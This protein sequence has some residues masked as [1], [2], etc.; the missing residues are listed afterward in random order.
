MLG[1]PLVNSLR[2]RGLRW[3]IG[4]IADSHSGAAN[5]AVRIAWT[6]GAAEGSATEGDGAPE[7]NTASYTGL[8]PSNKD[9]GRKKIE[10]AFRA[11]RTV[12]AGHYWRAFFEPAR[13]VHNVAGLGK[14]PN[15]FYYWA[16]EDLDKV[17]VFSRTPGHAQ[18]IEPRATLPQSGDGYFLPPNT[19]LI[20]DS[21]GSVTRWPNLEFTKTVPTTLGTLRFRYKP[22]CRTDAVNVVVAHE[23]THRVCYQEAVVN[24][25]AGDQDHDQVP[26]QWEAAFG[27]S[28][29]PQGRQDSFGLNLPGSIQDFEFYAYINGCFAGGGFRA[30]IERQEP[31][32]TWVDVT[33]TLTYHGVVP[34][35][36]VRGDDWSEDGYRW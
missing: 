17:C 19:L 16:I 12:R 29:G 28:T 7:S 26:D 1:A 31:D 6:G 5:Q 36:S 14:V 18:F 33:S 20:K 24:N 4:E 34:K 9:F 25:P 10:L 11:Q 32:G 13:Q 23:Q 8:P 15:W 21:V 27:M 22:L 30:V 3:R 35:V 2:E